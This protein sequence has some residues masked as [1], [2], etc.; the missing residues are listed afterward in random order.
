MASSLAAAVAAALMAGSALAAGPTGRCEPGA[1]PLAARF[2]VRVT[3][4]A[5]TATPVREQT[6]TFIRDA[7]QVALLKGE[8]DEIW[9]RDAAG[10]IGFQ[11]VFHADR[12]VVDYSPGELAT[13]NVRPDW[14]VLSCF[15]DPQEPAAAGSRQRVGWS[16]RLDLPLHLERRSADGTLT[17]IR[18]VAQFPAAPAVWPLPGER[19]AD[20]LHLDAADFGDMDYEPVVRKSETLDLRAGWRAPHSH[21]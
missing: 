5:G 18:L 3:P 19:S 14:M 17:R 20:Y 13:L 15:V 4:P 7:R 2:Q 10:R 11:R 6:W 12:Q 9:N 16:R 21:D 8:V 1:A